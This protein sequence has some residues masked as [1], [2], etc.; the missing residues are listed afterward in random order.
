MRIAIMADIHGNAVALDAVI[1]DIGHAVDEYWILGDIVALAHLLWRF[2]NEFPPCQPRVA[3][4]AIPNDMFAPEIALLPRSKMP[5]L[6]RH[7]YRC[8]SKLPDRSHGLRA[9]Y[10][11]HIVNVGSVSNP[12]RADVRASYVVLEADASGYCLEH[13]R[14]EYNCEAVIEKIVRLRHPGARYIVKHLRGL[15]DS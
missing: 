15:G 9:S 6:I 4:A 10:G 7:A 8:L 2:L 5:E 12:L 13:R 14:V 1:H 11:K 3:Y